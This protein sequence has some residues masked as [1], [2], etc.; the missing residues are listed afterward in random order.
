MS[1][2]SKDYDIID[3]IALQLRLDYNHLNQ[4]L[5]VFKLASQLNITLT[6]YTSLSNSQIDAI[7]KFYNFVNDGFTIIK[8]NSKKEYEF[9]TFYN[10]TLSNERVR[11]TIAHEIKHVV[12]LDIN[13]SEK[14]EA[15]ADHFAR[16]LLAPTC[17][18]EPYLGDFM[19]ISNIAKDF[20]ISY[21]AAKYAYSSAYNRFN[22]I[23]FKYTR[24]EIEFLNKQKK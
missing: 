1:I 15:L 14:E 21:E 8:H 24:E 10:D 7:S 11:F 18:L 16:Q 3:N 20:G 6:K 23:K 9:Y 19:H 12:C 13:L 5:D 2:S 4:Y 22:S 17:L